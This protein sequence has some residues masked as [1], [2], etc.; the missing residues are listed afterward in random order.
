MT[1]VNENSDD[2]RVKVLN[3]AT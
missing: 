2:N 3:F 1:C